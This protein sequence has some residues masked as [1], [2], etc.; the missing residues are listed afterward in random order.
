MIVI[1]SAVVASYAIYRTLNPITRY[2]EGE[3]T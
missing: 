3:E 2:R 1:G